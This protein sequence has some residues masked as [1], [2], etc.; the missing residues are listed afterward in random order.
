MCRLLTPLTLYLCFVLFAISA[1]TAQEYKI[2]E[3]PVLPG[4]TFV[5]TAGINKL[6][7]V[8]GSA[9][10]PAFAGSYSDVILYSQGTT[11]DLEILP[12][13][14]VNLGE[15]VNDSGQVIGFS[16]LKDWAQAA[17]Y[18]SG[19]VFPTAIGTLSG[20]VNAYGQSINN[21][22]QITGAADAADGYLHAFLYSAGTMNDLG[23]LPN[24]HYSKG[25]S[26][27][28]KGQIT[29]NGDTGNAMHAFIYQDGQLNDIGVLPGGTSSGGTAINDCG[30]VTGSSDSARTR[31]HAILYTH[32]RM[33][34]LGVLPGTVRS[35]GNALNNY[36]EVV[37]AVDDGESLQHA[38]V[39]THGK[40]KDL[41]DL[42]PPNSGWVLQNAT[43]INDE[44]E[45][46]VT[47]TDTSS[48]QVNHGFLLTPVH[49][50]R[51]SDDHGCRDDQ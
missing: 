45:I 32:G 3:I 25:W 27:N 21:S 23:V 35:F 43:G 33:K 44:G 24:G 4:G 51:R 11:Q 28:K 6:G 26:I 37:G 41:N 18:S 14:S 20:G 46:A 22:G 34:D 10:N 36:G 48:S 5:Q 17:L 16:V 12:G 30:Q 13:F 40:L 2:A 9:N 50:D 42:I 38:F 15:D 8:T 29:G 19:S 49:R 1:A 7:Q 47:G 39:Y 31:A